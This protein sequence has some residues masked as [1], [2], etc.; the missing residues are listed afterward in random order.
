MKRSY[1]IL[2]FATLL[3]FS[4]STE[5]KYGTKATIDIKVKQVGA[6]YCEVAFTPSE[7][8]WYYASIKEMENGYNP[9]S[10]NKKNFMN[11]TLDEAYMEY[12]IWRHGMLEQG[13]PFIADF[14][15]HALAYGDLN[16]FEY[17][18]KPDTDYLI[19][20]Y[21]VDPASNKPTGELFTQQI[22]TE[23]VTKNHVYY[24]YRIKGHWDY[25]YPKNGEGKIIEN[26][27]WIGFTRDEQVVS[28][29]GKTPREY[30]T[31][32]YNKQLESKEGTVWRGMYAHQNNGFG[33]GTSETLF[34]SGHTYYTAV[35][36]FDGPL[37]DLVIF[38]FTWTGTDMDLYLVSNN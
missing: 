28:A 5:A 10:H 34:I 35:M 38:R 32:L 14:A 26:I 6:G 16:R 25:V 29:S 23:P 21:V 9:A 30:F 13:V 17:Y 11:L 31:D 2:I 24:E 19:Y 27:P 36:T 8:T 12:I 20:C 1:L 22:H 18:L 3:A 4:C 33:D 37:S 15:S 7:I